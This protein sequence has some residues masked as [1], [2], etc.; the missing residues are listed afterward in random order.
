[1]ENATAIPDTK[2]ERFIRIAERRVNQVL[3]ALDR[4]EN[5]ANRHNYTYEETDVKRIFNELEKRLR[6][7]RQTFSAAQDSRNKFT[8]QK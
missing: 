2:R 3:D 7:I 4:L 8:L 5:C 6:E 1:M